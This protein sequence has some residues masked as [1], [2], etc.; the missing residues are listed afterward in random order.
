[1]IKVNLVGVTRKKPK[2][3]FKIALPSSSTPIFLIL[4]VLG[5]A[6]FGYS[7]Y[8]GLTGESARLDTEIQAAQTRKAQLDAI[9]KQDQIYETRKKMLENRVKI[10][11]GL[12]KNQV[13]PVVALDVL[14]RAVDRTQYVWL[15]T[16]DQTNAV[17]TMNGTGTSL[18][19]IADF[20]SNLQATGYFKNIDVSNAQDTSG[21][22]TFALKCEF[23]PPSTTAPA[24]LPTPVGGN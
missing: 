5:S 24:E 11:E 18:L 4:I 6:A 14:S 1:M 22:F 7:W 23:S 12:Q 8:A 10:I 21:N 19:A 3:A 9:I 16:L 17:F 13:S 15:S 20:Y 2:A